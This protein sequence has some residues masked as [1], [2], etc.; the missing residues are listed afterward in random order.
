VIA[1]YTLIGGKY[2]EK[3]TFWLDNLG[4]AG[5]SNEAPPPIDSCSPVTVQDGRVTFQP[6]GEPVLSFDTDGLTATAAG[7]FVDYWKK[8]R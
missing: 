6:A 5:I 4:K 7:R 1:H 8:L 2:C 3:R